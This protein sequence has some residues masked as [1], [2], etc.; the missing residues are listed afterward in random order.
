MTRLIDTTLWIDLTRAKS[1]SSLKAF[2]APYVNDPDSQLAEPVAFELLR[3][4]TED[5]EQTLLTYFTTIP[6]LA[7]PEDLSGRRP[8]GWDA[9]V[10]RAASHQA[11]WTF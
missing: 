2:V 6:F 7:T 8:P 4:A 3:Y 1:P 9:R 5:E 11:R 10:E